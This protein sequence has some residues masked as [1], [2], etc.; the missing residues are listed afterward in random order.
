MLW[1]IMFAAIE[2]SNSIVKTLYTNWRRQKDV[3]SKFM[4]T[5]HQQE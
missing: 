4:D 1:T 3:P 2:L 5:I